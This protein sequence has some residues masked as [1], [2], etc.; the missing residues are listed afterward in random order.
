[1]SL[2][3]QFFTLAMMIGSGIGMGAAF[4]GYR[5]VSNELRI[6]R[7]WIP[8]LDL[9]Y[10]MTATLA[11]FRVLTA[12]N[13][14]EVRFYVFIGL[15]IG[16]S[17]YFWLLSGTCIKFFRWSIGAARA[18]Y[19]F[20]IRTGELLIVKPLLGLY[21]F[22]RIF[23]SFVLVTAMFLLRIVL[24]LLRPFWQLLVW[25]L[26]PIVKPVWQR[27]AAWAERSGL[28][29]AAARIAAWIRMTWNRWF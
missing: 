17:F 9:L 14:G 5:V 8:V 21:R 10:W 3:V 2:E 29:T 22:L 7:L 16:I 11:V 19:R 25:M 4:D 1:M 23:L 12:S 20:A 13:E 6:G 18:A 28:R 26:R 15:F 27:I 24:Q